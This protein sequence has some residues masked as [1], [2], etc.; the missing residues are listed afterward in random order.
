MTASRSA[1]SRSS[2][3]SST[4]ALRARRYME[5]LRG[6]GAREAQCTRREGVRHSTAH[7]G[8]AGQRGVVGRRPPARGQWAP[9]PASAAG[10]PEILVWRMHARIREAECKHCGRGWDGRPGGTQGQHSL[11]P[12]AVAPVGR[13][14][15]QQ[16]GR[17]NGSRPPQSSQPRPSPVVSTPRCC[18]N[19]AK[20]ARRRRGRGH[21]CR[22]ARAR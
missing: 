7:E 6:G 5:S 4:Q 18:W 14:T 16:P 22:V 13:S 15:R 20:A 21:A 8:C 1:A 9:A 19:A 11:R 3:S 10:L 12:G 17:G 2:K